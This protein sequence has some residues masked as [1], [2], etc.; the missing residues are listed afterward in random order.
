MSN[1]LEYKDN[2]GLVHVV[3][4]R[5]YG[6]TMAL[7]V[8]MDYE[9]VFQEVS[10]AYVTAQRSYNPDSGYKFSAYFT[11]AAQNQI[12]KSLGILTGAKRLNEDEKA[13]LVELTKENKDR[14]AQGM[15]EKSTYIGLS[16]C[17]LEA[18]SDES[19]T[20]PLDAIA[21]LG[22]DPEQLASEAQEWEHSLARL[23]PLANVLA[24]L[25]KEPPAELLSELESQFEYAKMIALKES[26]RAIKPYVTLRA[27]TDFVA[28]ISDCRREDLTVAEAEL[29]Q[30]ASRL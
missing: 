22:K 27:V 15:E 16:V 17:S 25:L 6:W 1:S 30:A 3:A 24:E 21:S 29:L 5:Y 4:R 28:I 20:N 7:G 10:L 23:S 2:I 26:G 14:L 13:A 8:S 19:G 12:R 9:D 18:L 11:R